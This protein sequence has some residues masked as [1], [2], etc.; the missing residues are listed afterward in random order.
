MAPEL[1]EAIISGVQDDELIELL[2]TQFP[3][4]VPSRARKALRDLRKKGVAE[5]PLS[6]K[7]VD[8]PMVK[9]CPPD[10]DVF[11]PPD[12]ID[13]QQAPYVFYR[14]LMTAQDVE[15]KVRTE[16]WDREWADYVI[17]HYRGQINSNIK[18]DYSNRGAGTRTNTDSV[19]SDLIEVLFVY[20]RLIDD[21]DGSEG[22]YCTVIHPLWTGSDTEPQYAKF[23]LKN[24]LEDYPL[25]V[26]PLG[27]DSRSLYDVQ[28]FADLLRG[29]QWHIKTGRDQHIDADSLRVLPPMMYPEGRPPPE[30]GAG[31]YIPRRRP[32]DYE[33]GDR[34]APDPSSWQTDDIL[35]KQADKLVGLDF[36]S[37][38]AQMRNQYYIDKFLQHVQ[39]VLKMVWK[40][41]LMYGPQKLFFRVTGMAQA[42]EMIKQDSEELD[43]FVSFD[44]QNS[45][46][47]LVEKKLAQFV[48][49]L[50]LDRQGKINVNN[51]L[52]IAGAAIDP[53]L[54]DAI[55]QPTEVAQEEMVRQVTDDLAKIF[56]GI[57]VPARPQGAEIALGIIQQYAQQPDIQQRA[58]ADEVFGERLSKYAEQY[59]FQLQQVMNAQIGRIGTQPASMGGVQ[60]QG[61]NMQ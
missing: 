36:E 45:D 60:T 34:P 57:E 33:F 1:A 56:A 12:T 47:E 24:G 26:T 7:S 4:V 49:L 59:Q 10:A 35:L 25:V 41:Y 20:Q 28:T 37:P 39:E 15:G 38:L 8:A 53:V 2:K 54:A 16:G 55:L 42:E 19:E 40:N 32:T 51:L 23:E 61:V 5:L 22:I 11:F 3:D 30:W 48:Q 14:C 18:S 17:E 43:L 31:R 13:P 29:T 50:G 27:E 6:Q 52:E 44:T 58:Q 21:E 46:P 9:A